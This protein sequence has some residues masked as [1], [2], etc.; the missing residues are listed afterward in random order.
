M[1]KLQ[2]S[3]PSIAQV[4]EKYSEHRRTGDIQHCSEEHLFPENIQE[5]QHIYNVEESYIFLP[6]TH[7]GNVLQPN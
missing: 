5:H 7:R 1:E 4:E 2:A 6:N 3:L